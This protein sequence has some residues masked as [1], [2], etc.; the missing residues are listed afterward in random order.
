VLAEAEGELRA[1]VIATGSEL[2]LALE[3]RDRL[4]AEGIGTRVVSMPSWTLFARE[5]AAYRDEVLPPAITARVAVEAGSPMGWER[6]TGS[7]GRMV[8]ISHFGASAPAKRV[9]EALGFTAENVANKVKA[10]LG[11]IS[12]QPAEGGREGAGPAK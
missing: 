1:I 8:G 2:S 5:S 6:W 3:T 10:A 11:L 4:H 12:D 9:F 7:A